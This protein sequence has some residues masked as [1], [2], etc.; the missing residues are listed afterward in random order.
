MSDHGGNRAPAGQHV[1]EGERLH[2]KERLVLAEARG[3][4]HPRN[5]EVVGAVVGVGEEI[6]VIE[7]RRGA[8]IPVLARFGGHVIGMLVLPGEL[9]REGEAI[10]WL[11]VGD[12]DAVAHAPDN[13]RRLGDA[14]RRVAV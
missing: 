3:P 1:L 14:A 8:P 13:E 2:L 12:D 5:H 10:A 9:V 4:F 11:R 6:G 7:Q